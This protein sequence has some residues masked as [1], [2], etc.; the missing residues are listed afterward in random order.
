VCFNKEGCDGGGTQ[1]KLKMH[2]TLSLET[3]KWNN[4]LGDGGVVGNVLFAACHGAQRDV[5]IGAR[6]GW[7]WKLSH[8]LSIRREEPPYPS[9]KAG[10]H[11]GSGFWR[12]KKSLA[13]SRNQTLDSL[14]CSESLYQLRNCGQVQLLRLY[15]FRLWETGSENVDRIHLAQDKDRN[16][17]VVNSHE[18]SDFVNAAHYVT[19]RTTVGP[20]SK[21]L[22]HGVGCMHF[23][24][25]AATC[26]HFV[27]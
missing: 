1:R 15:G 4:N 25:F 23:V 21:I 13:S 2:T 24:N 17:P 19:S 22:Q 8:G 11:P 12:K 16:R 5:W 6:R 9:K 26:Q 27:D 18:I 20:W 14:A 10:W 7:W 3:P